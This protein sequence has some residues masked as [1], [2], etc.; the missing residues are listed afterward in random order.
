MPRPPI[1]RSRPWTPTSGA[2]AGDTFTSERQYRNALA[3]QHGYPSWY[4]QQQ[5]PGPE[6][7]GRRD[8]R[9]LRPSEQIAYE[10]TGSVLTRMRHGLSL[11]RA[12]RLEHTTPA[13]VK[14]HAGDALV[15]SSHGTFLVTTTDRHFRRLLFVT[16][17]GVTI[18]E[19]RDSRA[20]SAVAEYDAAI[21][22]FL[23]K[24][25]PSG[26]ARFEG[27]VLRV[28]RKRYPYVTDLNTLE[29]LGRRGEI[30]FESIYASAA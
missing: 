15:P 22:R 10:K 17:D 11:T 2:F 14:R 12:A 30:S 28:G 1:T 13:A 24:G 8:F 19:T 18:V 29:W 16:S 23:A 7:R 4:A 27:Q 21:Q 25:D 26:L 6:V 20:A 3:R 5:A 9:R